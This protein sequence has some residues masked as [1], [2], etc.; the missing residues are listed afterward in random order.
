MVMKIGHR[1]A[2]WYAPENTF[3]SF[4]KALD[5]KVDMIELDIHVCKSWEI[6][7]IHD[8][9]LDRTTN[10]IWLVNDKI[11]D[12]LNLLNAW[13]G[14]SILSL[15]EV[16]NLV[17][18]KCKINIELKWINTVIKLSELLNEY[19]KFN[20]WSYDDFMVSSFRHKDLLEF[21]KLIPEIKLWVL[22][23]HLPINNA[24]FAEW[25]PYYSINI[26]ECFISKDFIDDAHK[27]GFLVY[28]YTANT[29]D[30]IIKLQ[31][32]KIDWIFSNFPDLI[33]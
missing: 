24:E 2:C 30:T 6:V 12:E 1:G 19:I 8:D 20:N 3:S 18:R 23:G 7:V 31:N 5:L 22:I 26:N 29:I 4:Q 14:E 9:T 13:N 28:A 10:W 21:N 11:F 32:L 33:K 16:L 25:L 15:R 27:R 17:D